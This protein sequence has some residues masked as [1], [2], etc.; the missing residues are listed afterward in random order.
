M[1]LLGLS[2][3]IAQDQNGQPQA[4]KDPWLGCWGRAYDKAHLAKHPG[5]LVTGFTVA[6]DART[7]Q[8]DADPGNYGARIA[9]N[10]RGKTE[11]YTGPETARCA[12][13]G[14]QKDRLQC[15]VDGVFLGQFTLERAGKNVKISLKD[16]QDRLVLVPGVDVSGFIRLTPD[17]PEHS[18]FLLNPAS[19]EACNG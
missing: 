18:V 8:G 19:D 13:I 15:F 16:K 10:F 17:N 5:Q 12:P 6:I 9:A 3:G 1:L 7:P 11:T 4:T 14:A 2:S